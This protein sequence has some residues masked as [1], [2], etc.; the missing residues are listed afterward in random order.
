M[1]GFARACV[2]VKRISA[3]LQP[4]AK[5]K[6]W[7][8]FVGLIP[9]RRPVISGYYTTQWATMIIELKQPAEAR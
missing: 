4:T 8:A 1:H 9:L 5:F 6:L 3:K 2:V 7:V